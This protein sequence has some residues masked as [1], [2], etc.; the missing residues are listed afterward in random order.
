[1]SNNTRVGNLM[2]MINNNSTHFF[3]FF[4]RLEYSDHLANEAAERIHSND[5]T[6]PNVS[7]WVKTKC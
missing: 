5:K 3:K 1:M 6:P 7:I 2:C 4:Y